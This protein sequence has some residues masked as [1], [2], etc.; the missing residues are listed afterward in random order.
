MVHASKRKNSVQRVLRQQVARAKE[1][2]ND[3]GVYGLLGPQDQNAR[4]EPSPTVTGQRFH[5]PVQAG[6]QRYQRYQG[7]VQ[8]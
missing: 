6:E 8:R 3:S 1:R 5:G 2:F 7:P 4:Q